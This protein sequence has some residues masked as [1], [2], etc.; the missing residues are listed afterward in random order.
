MNNTFSILYRSLFSYLIIKDF[1]YSNIAIYRCN[2]IL[3]YLLIELAKHTIR[4]KLK[5]ESVVLLWAKKKDHIFVTR[6]TSIMVIAP[7][8]PDIR[9]RHAFVCGQALRFAVKY[10]R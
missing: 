5:H 9:P 3:S 10:S 7:I 4:I 1:V 6:W 8:Q 2:K